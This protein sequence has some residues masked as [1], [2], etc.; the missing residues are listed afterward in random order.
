VPRE[1]LSRALAMHS[2]QRQIAVIAGPSVAGLVLAFAGPALCY[3]Q[4]HTSRWFKK[5]S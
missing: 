1:D 4:F 5:M 3:P 2:S